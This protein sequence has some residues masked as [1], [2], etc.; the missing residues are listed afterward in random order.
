MA[1]TAEYQLAAAAVLKIVQADIEKNVPVMF[2]GEIPQDIVKQFAADAA[3][4]AIDTVDAD[5]AKHDAAKGM[6]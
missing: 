6:D 4:A 5:R 2:Q 3:K 1:T